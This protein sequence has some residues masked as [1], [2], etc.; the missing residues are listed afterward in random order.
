MH[1]RTLHAGNREISESPPANGARGR[2]EKVM[3]HKSDMHDSEKSD[4]RIVPWK[5]SNKGEG[6]VAQII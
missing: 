3:N 5:R 2:S 6:D 1:V 4:S